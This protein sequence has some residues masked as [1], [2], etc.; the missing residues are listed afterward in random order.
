[1]SSLNNTLRHINQSAHDNPA[2]FVRQ[3]EDRF[4]RN[5]DRIAT[6]IAATHGHKLVL[7]AGPSG[8][9]K[10]TCAGMLANRLQTA[11]RQTHLVSLDDFYLPLERL[12][13]LDDGTR[14][15]ESIHALDLPLL[16]SVLRGLMETGRGDLP[17]FDFKTGKRGVGQNIT[18]DDDDLVVVEGLHALH[19]LV[20]GTLAQSKVH[21]EQ[22][23]KMYIS[24][25]LRIYDDRWNIVLNKRNLRLCRRILRDAQF[26]N[27]PALETL[28]MWSSVTRG[29]EQ[30]LAPCKPLA[31]ICVNSIHLYE[32]CV[33]RQR[34]LPMLEQ[35][36]EH[37][38]AARLA[39]AL[40]RFEVIPEDHT[41]PQSLLRE[42]LGA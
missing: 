8:S 19:P 9:G 25:S 5:L 34:L 15:I 3:C 33:F 40:R 7:L 18:L 35:L 41:P 31:D 21:V 24:V 26:R 1:M 23:T 39:H 29:E 22:I 6:R 20:A 4:A 36:P 16:E 13:V 14:D 37:K 38:E 32:P 11:T 28:Q 17:S 10:T 2:D 42:F 12:P 30:N 27:T